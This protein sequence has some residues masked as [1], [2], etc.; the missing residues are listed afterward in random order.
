MQETFFFLFKNIIGVP[1]QNTIKKYSLKCRQRISMRG[2]WQ[3]KMK[4]YRKYRELEKI[5]IY[6]FISKSMLQL[7]RISQIQNCLF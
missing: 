1:K 2:T 5:F 6:M 3:C 7:L 4:R